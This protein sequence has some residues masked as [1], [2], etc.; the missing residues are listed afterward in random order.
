MQSS[1]L[2]MRCVLFRNNEILSLSA[3][4]CHLKEQAQFDRDEKEVMFAEEV[5]C[6]PE[7]T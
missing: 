3:Q 2:K 6:A 5:F 4:V 7:C 1:T